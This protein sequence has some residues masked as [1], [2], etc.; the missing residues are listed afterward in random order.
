[1]VPEKETG[2]ADKEVAG[3]NDVEHQTQTKYLQE[4]YQT[5]LSSIARFYQQYQASEQRDRKKYAQQQPE[6]TVTMSEQACYQWR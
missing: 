1:L 5:R 4:I 2:P 3:R 6:R